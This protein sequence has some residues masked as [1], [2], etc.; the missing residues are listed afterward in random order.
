[1][2]D[3]NFL[4]FQEEIKKTMNGTQN[5]FPETL[6][7]IESVSEIGSRRSLVDSRF[8]RKKKSVIRKKQSL[9]ICSPQKGTQV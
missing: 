2:I 7:A 3:S 9:T 5:G 4:N 6:H 1:M 8:D